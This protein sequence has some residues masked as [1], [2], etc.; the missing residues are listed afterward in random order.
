[1]SERNT[2]HPWQRRRKRREKKN[3]STPQIRPD[4]K[5]SNFSEYGTWKLALLALCVLSLSGCASLPVAVCPEPAQPPP[6]LMQAPPG[7]DRVCE[8]GKA[9]Y[10][11]DP[12]SAMQW[13]SSPTAAR[14]IGNN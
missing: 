4:A 9:L 5:P 3:G 1:M 10:P 8:M 12:T 6:A 11:T 13:C 2:V 14:V 7:T